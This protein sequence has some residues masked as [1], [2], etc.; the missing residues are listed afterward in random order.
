MRSQY[1]GQGVWAELGGRTFMSSAVSPDGTVK[2]IWKHPE[3]PGDSRFTFEEKWNRWTATVPVEDCDRLYEVSSFTR[4]RGIP[5]QVMSI[6][7]SGRALLYYVG[8]SGHEA[9]K[10]GFEQTDPGTY[11]KIVP[12][13][14][15]YDYHEEHRD[16]LFDHWR[17]VNFPQPAEERA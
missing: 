11:S 3:A 7:D 5:C 12:V 13:G 2:L 10:N 1:P 9:E 15:L 14:D 17:R 16:L 6:D 4:Y 8:H